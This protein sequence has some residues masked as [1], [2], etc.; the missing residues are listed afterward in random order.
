MESVGGGAAPN[1]SRPGPPARSTNGR[2]PWLRLL[3]DGVFDIVGCDQG[4]R[5]VWKRQ[6]APVRGA[7]L[8]GGQN[9][10]AYSASA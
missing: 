4:K 3:L 1:P 2:D 6:R 9:A 5:L 8:D 7:Y 10:C